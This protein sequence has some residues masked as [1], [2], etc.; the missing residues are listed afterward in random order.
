MKWSPTKDRSSEI[1]CI[2]IIVAI[3]GL[4]IAAYVGFKTL[5]EVIKAWT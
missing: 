2:L 1:T 5:A 4:S 3:A